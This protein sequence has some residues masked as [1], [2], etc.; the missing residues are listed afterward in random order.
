MQPF[1]QQVTLEGRYRT[2]LTLW[3][4]FT[5]SVGIFFLFTLWI[6][7]SEVASENPI[8]SL[9]FLIV[10]ILSVIASYF[11]KQRLLARSVNEQNVQLV[12][13]GLHF[14]AALS[15]F[16]A[17]LGIVDYL[18]TGHRYYYLLM[19]VALIGSL[20]NFPRRDH[21]LAASYKS[22]EPKDPWK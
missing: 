19:I 6:S 8:L 10:G 3:F 22:S 13:A 14:A 20:L 2:L 16:A 9:T 15:E 21:L 5:L 12:H 1:N 7:P 11:V 18:L 17:M 4:A